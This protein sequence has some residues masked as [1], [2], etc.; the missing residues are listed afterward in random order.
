MQASSRSSRWAWLGPTLL[1][2]IPLGLLQGSLFLNLFFAIVP[3]NVLA[4]IGLSAALYLLIP[5]IA[6]FFKVRQSSG[7]ASESGLAGLR[8]GACAI[9]VVIIFAG[10]RM[11]IYLLTPLPPP[12]PHSLTLARPAVTVLQS[13]FLLL[14]IGLNCFGLALASLG[15]LLGGW[16]GRRTLAPARAA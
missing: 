14:L 11:V 6:R 10:V 13:L 3:L 12:A 8:I 9:L 4:S 1:W 2:G 7:Q 15:G 5:A 16:L